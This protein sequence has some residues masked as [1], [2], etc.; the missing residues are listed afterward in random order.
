LQVNFDGGFRFNDNPVKFSDPIDEK[1]KT[2]EKFLTIEMPL[3]AS[4]ILYGPIHL[5]WQV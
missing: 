1:S 3:N 4:E 5:T 2:K